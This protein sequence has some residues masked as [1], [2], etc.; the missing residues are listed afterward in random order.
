MKSKIA[1]V[2]TNPNGE[3]GV[4]NERY[5]IQVVQRAM[6]IMDALLE[7]RHALSLEEISKRSDTPRST[8]FRIL[9]NLIQH[10]YITETPDGYWL[11]LKLLSMGAAVEANLDFRSVALPEMRALRER[12]GETVYMAVLSREMQVVYIERLASEHPYGVVMANVGMTAPMHSTAL[13]KLLAA[14]LPIERVQAWLAQH[15]LPPRTS[16]TLTNVDQLVEELQAIRAR[17]YSTD[18]GEYYDGIRCI[19]APLFNSR[20]QAVAAISV[21][22]PDSRMPM[23]LVGSALA[24]DVVETAKRVSAAMGANHRG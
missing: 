5:Q 6:R 8:V 20:R 22:G 9:T 4:Q 11:G 1:S 19:A 16:N 15:D 17:G 14:H 7:A 21:A 10:D 12:V 13:G 24:S 2:N 18:D 3:Y 23:P